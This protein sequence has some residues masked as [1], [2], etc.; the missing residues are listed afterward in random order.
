M[1]YRP[2]PAQIR[3]HHRH[4]FRYWHSLWRETGFEHYRRQAR[5]HAEQILALKKEHV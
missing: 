5:L 1:N 2:T 4:F 3:S